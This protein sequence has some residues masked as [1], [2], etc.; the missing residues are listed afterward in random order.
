MSRFLYAL[1]SLTAHDELILTRKAWKRN[2]WLMPANRYNF[3]REAGYVS[4]T[5]I[6]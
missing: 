6:R 1:A 2:R 5:L 4:I 3:S